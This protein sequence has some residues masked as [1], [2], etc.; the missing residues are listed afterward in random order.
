MSST[1]LMADFSSRD[2][3]D[4]FDAIA[5]A[6]DRGLSPTRGANIRVGD[7]LAIAVGWLILGSIILYP[8]LQLGV[9]AICIALFG[10]RS[11][12]RLVLGPVPHGG[13]HRDGRSFRMA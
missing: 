8:S 3:I 7:A 10:T 4:G 5:G 12:V 13:L 2:A 11:F 6:L 1:D 9:I